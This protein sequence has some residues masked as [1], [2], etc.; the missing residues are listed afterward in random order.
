VLPPDG[1]AT[2][3]EA[4]AD[5]VRAPRFDP[6]ELR[7]EL[8][9]IVEEAKRKRDTPPAV[10]QETLHALLFDVHRVRRWRIGEEAAIAGFTRDD[11]AGYHATRYVPARAIVAVAGGVDA[12][13]ALK[14]LH[15]AWGDWA[16][17]AP[18]LPPGPAEPART[19]RR[20][21]T[22]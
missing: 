3:V 9:V 2:G 15:A 19:G 5:A 6:V 8:G 14:L 7:R 4:L 13:V 1:L 18:P 21:R 12:D 10:A 22:L 20:A 17:P 16:A 11:V